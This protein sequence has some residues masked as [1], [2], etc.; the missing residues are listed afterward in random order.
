[1]KNKFMYLTAI[2][3]VIVAVVL[4]GCKKDKEKRLE[5]NTSN[6][7]NPTCRVCEISYNDVSENEKEMVMRNLS[8]LRGNNNDY[9]IIGSIPTQYDTLSLNSYVLRKCESESDF[10]V[11]TFEDGSDVAVYSLATTIS[12]TQ[13][14][15]SVKTYVVE[16]KNNGENYFGFSFEYNSSNNTF[17]ALEGP[18][19]YGPTIGN[20]VLECIAIVYSA[21]VSDP[22][23]DQLCG[24]APEYCV[25]AIIVSCA[26]HHLKGG[27]AVANS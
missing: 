16:M 21:C 5:D 10:H 26:I 6:I 18:I 24:Y 20:N 13:E 14:L 8:S 19:C 1:M 27:A 9:E 22:E 4:V 11:I 25:T 12:K 7:H 3:F 23:C 17:Q 2:I 15:S